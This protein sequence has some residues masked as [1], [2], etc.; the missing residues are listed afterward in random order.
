MASDCDQWI[1]KIN[2]EAG[3]RVDEA[4]W[5]ARQNVDQIYQ[6]CKDGKMAEAQKTAS[7]TMALLGIKP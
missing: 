3:I 6:L 7:D 4:G 5:K 2:A 1:A